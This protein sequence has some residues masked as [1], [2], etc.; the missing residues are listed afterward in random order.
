MGV[1]FVVICLGISQLVSAESPFAIYLTWQRDPTTTMTI[2]WLTTTNDDKELDKVSYKKQGEDIAWEE[3]EGTHIPFPGDAQYTLHSIELINL[4]PDTLYEVKVLSDPKTC[5]RFQTMPATLEKPIIF[6]EGGDTSPKGLPLFEE[7][8]RQA[9]SREPLFTLFGGDL[10]YAAKKKLE[11]GKD[12]LRWIHWLRSYM[13]S[14]VTPSGRLVPIISAIGNH[15]VPGFYDQNKETASSFYALFPFPEDSTF[16]ALR[17]GSYLTLYFLDTDHTCD[18]KGPQTVWLKNTLA[19]DA[20]VTHKIAVYHAPG[21]PSVR[22]FRLEVSTAVRRHWV[23]IF[24]QYGLHMAFEHHEHAYK[25]THP[26][27]DSN[28]HPRG[29]VY[30]GDGAWGGK[31]RTPKKAGRTTYLAKT[32]EAPHFIEVKLSSNKRELWATTPTGVVIDHF[33]QNANSR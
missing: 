32:E 21:Y 13:N 1:W 14:M 9:A 22:Y 15:D 29:I 26:L 10:A 4:F 28:P 23:P 20:K 19:Q 31:V 30:V 8:C 11:S 33:I 27:I 5:Y 6:V 18:I 7:T 25:R 17:F 16:H 2:Q 12:E 3:K 24:E